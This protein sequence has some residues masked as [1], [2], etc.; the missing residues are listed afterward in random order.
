MNI[1]NR[2]ESAVEMLHK[3]KDAIRAVNRIPNCKVTSVRYD[4]NYDAD[5]R[6][7]DW[8]QCKEVYTK[9]PYCR[10]LD[11]KVSDTKAKLFKI[12]DVQMR[13]KDRWSAILQIEVDGTWHTMTSNLQKAPFMVKFICKEV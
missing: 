7:P 6:D 10:W 11:K 3:L 4:Y 8:E 9:I 1:D 12:G 2:I 5:A 13:Y